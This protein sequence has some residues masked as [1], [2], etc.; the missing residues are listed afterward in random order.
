MDPKLIGA[1]GV[2][3]MCC[4]CSIIVYGAMMGGE[5]DPGAAGAG[6]GA[7]SG[8]GTGDTEFVNE[9][10]GGECPTLRNAAGLKLVLQGDGNLV[11]YDANGTALWN[12]GTHGQG[13]APYK[14]V[15]QGDGNLVLYAANG[16]VLWH[17]VT[18]GQGVAPYRLVLQDDHNL[19]LYA[20]GGPI[21]SSGTAV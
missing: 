18:H 8:A 2:L 20:A 6:A 5:E 15:L 13:V 21:W 1:F 4:I 14:L 7:G 10:T 17:T 9:C 19:V 16:T 12:T 11:L 3:S